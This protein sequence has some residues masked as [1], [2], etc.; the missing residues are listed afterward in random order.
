MT[1]EVINSVGDSLR[2]LYGVENYF[3]VEI[4]PLYHALEAVRDQFRLD[5]ESLYEDAGLAAT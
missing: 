4:A 1:A 3:A 2:A 5:P